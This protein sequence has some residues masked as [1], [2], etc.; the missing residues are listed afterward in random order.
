MLGSEKVDAPRRLFWATV[1]MSSVVVLAS[2]VGG[3]LSDRTG[4]RKVFVG[5]ASFVFG[6]AMVVIALAG[7]FNGFVAGMAMVGSG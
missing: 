7:T 3:W 5:A 2:L 4:R 6:V 1:A